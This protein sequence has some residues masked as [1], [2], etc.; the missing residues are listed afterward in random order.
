MVPP[1]IHLKKSHGVYNSM[2]MKVW[3]FS[4]ILWN[5]AIFPAEVAILEQS[6]FVLSSCFTGI[7]LQMTLALDESNQITASI[8]CILRKSRHYSITELELD[9]S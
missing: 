6:Y 5:F 7:C 9:I 4:K 8:T 1:C 2:S 3:L